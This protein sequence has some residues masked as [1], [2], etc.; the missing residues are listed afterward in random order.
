MTV[1]NLCAGY[2]IGRTTAW[3]L[4]REEKLK[5]VRIGRRTLVLGASIDALFNPVQVGEHN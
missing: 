5:V 4:I 2:G 3:K 1:R